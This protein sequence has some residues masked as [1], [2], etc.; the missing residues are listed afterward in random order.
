MAKITRNFSLAEIQYSAT[1][2]RRGI[3]NVVPIDAYGVMQKLFNN[4]MQ[5]L[6]D[7]VGSIRTTS[8]FRC[9]ELNDA[10]GGSPFSQHIYSNKR[11]AACDFVHYRGEL[12]TVAL[13]NT[14]LKLRLPF[15]QLIL[16]YPK[17]YNGGWL[18][19]ST[20]GTESNDRFQ[21]LA[22]ENGK[23]YSIIDV[24]DNQWGIFLG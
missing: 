16:E 21:I 2:E 18:H 4:I 11:G 1:A 17:S 6:R 13:I 7:E 22:K 10:I 20:S 3:T 8:G 14:I 5:P 9:R 12:N 24:D 19:V 15:D 23:P